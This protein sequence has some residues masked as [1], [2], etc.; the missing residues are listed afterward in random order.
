MSYLPGLEAFAVT[1]VAAA[2]AVYN[3]I[4]LFLLRRSPGANMAYPQVFLDL[5]AL[6]AMLAFAGGADN[7][8]SLFYL[9]HVGIAGILF[10]RKRTYAVTAIACLLFCG[11]VLLQETHAWASHPLTTGGNARLPAIGP[12]LAAAVL[13]KQRGVRVAGILT[14]FIAA[15]FS[16][17]YF[18]TTL[19]A[20]LRQRNELILEAG[21]MLSTEQAK[22]EEIVR[23]IGAAM[24]VLERGNQMVW[25]NQK[26]YEWFGQD[27]AGQ[28][29]HQRLFNDHEA[30][31]GCSLG[32]VWRQRVCHPS[33]RTMMLD[34]QMRVFLV[35]CNP[36]GRASEQRLGLIQ[37]ITLMKEMQS[38][39]TQASKLS[40]IGR[41]AA[42]VAHE[43]NNP[44]AAV[45]SSAEILADR[46]FT[47]RSE[48]TGAGAELQTHL[49]R[50]QRNVYRCKKIIDNLLSFAR[51]PNETLERVDLR[52]V[53]E[54]V[55]DLVAA[56]ARARS[57]LVTFPHT[58]KHL[59]QGGPMSGGMDVGTCPD[60]MLEASRIH[61]IRQVLVN[62]VLNA[63]DASDDGKQVIIE[64]VRRDNGVELIV[65]DTGQGMA[66]EVSAHLFEPFF[67][68]KPVG[69]GTG[70]GLY[71]SRQMVEALHGRIGFETKPGEGTVFRVWLP[72]DSRLEEKRVRAGE[73]SRLQAA[74]AAS[75]MPPPQ[76]MQGRL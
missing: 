42:G 14:A 36:I 33:E 64:C 9:F 27:L 6:T 37:D 5:V 73:S 58:H 63:M 69:K 25:A 24:I 46:A 75:P 70:L 8:F 12:S 40:A 20:K 74:D 59:A 21:E 11:M 22:T 3:A 10:G 18:T 39:V 72:A 17:A 53:L 35:Q 76:S 68:T 52:C 23:S 38:Q 50:I 66:A 26:A 60:L 43:L 57:L 62:L 61:S 19:V 49:G 41:L 13:A 31:S 28:I 16:T 47:G 56:S 30:C 55:H 48:A 44:L 71:L 34:G 32:T 51:R 29:C 45:A 1:T 54:D 65:T 4:F 7:P 67:T 2:M 15:A